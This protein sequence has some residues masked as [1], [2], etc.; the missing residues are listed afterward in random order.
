L[1]FVAFQEANG[2][3]PTYRDLAKRTG[4]HRA[5][6]ASLMLWME[7]RGVVEI[8]RGVIRGVRLVKSADPNEAHAEGR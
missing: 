7:A 6:I 1:A 4:I 3:P 2:M 8:R 5:T